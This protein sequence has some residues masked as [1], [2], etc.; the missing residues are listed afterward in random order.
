MYFLTVEPGDVTLVTIAYMLDIVT[1]RSFDGVDVSSLYVMVTYSKVA[2]DKT[3][4]D[5]VNE[6]CVDWSVVLL[7][8][9]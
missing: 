3:E 1:M 2:V 7:V 4:D 5:I 9:G 6:K 8:Q